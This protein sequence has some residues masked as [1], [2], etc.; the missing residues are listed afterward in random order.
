[1]AAQDA[2]KFVEALK[3]NTAMQNDVEEARN[4]MVEVGKKHGYNFTQDE[5]H[6]ELRQRWGVTKAKD[7]PDTTTVG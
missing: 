2:T 7:D 6:D 5:L 4:R 1:M 3:T